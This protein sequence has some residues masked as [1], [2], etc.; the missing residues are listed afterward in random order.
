MGRPEA[1]QLSKDQREIKHRRPA[2]AGL[3]ETHPEKGWRGSVRG[4]GLE[5]PQEAGGWARAGSG[6]SV[7]THPGVQSSEEQLAADHGL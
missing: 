2:L 6:H 1:R 5:G 3:L 4:R 7:R